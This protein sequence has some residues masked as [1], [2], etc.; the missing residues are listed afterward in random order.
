MG[1]A[2]KFLFDVSFDQPDAASDA[3]RR[4]A[5]PTFS[6]ADLD[7]ARED[8]FNQGRNEALAEAA[9]A[10]DARIADALG[11]IQQGIDQLAADHRELSQ[12]T[13]RAAVS[14]VREILRQ[15][16]PALC[17]REAFAELEALVARCLAE[18][19]TEPRLVLRVNDGVFDQMQE[20]I[21]AVSQANGFAGKIVLLA[22]DTLGLTDGRIE[23]AD[24]GAERDP[25]RLMGE[26][27]AALTRMLASRDACPS[28]EET[29]NG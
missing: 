28:P 25:N 24:G 4:P 12:A 19:L 23:W 21:A 10:A 13:E 16:V 17:R 20:R 9:F 7:A 15:A 5:E 18:A 27:D 14:L 29:A 6:R 8:G 22:D 3:A 11:A 2:R 26:I 1:Q